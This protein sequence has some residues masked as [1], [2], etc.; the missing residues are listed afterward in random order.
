[1]GFCTCY[2]ACQS[3]HSFPMRSCDTYADSS[4]DILEFVDQCDQSWVVDIDA[5]SIVSS[6][7]AIL[8]L[9]CSHA[10]GFVCAIAGCFR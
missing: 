3:D 4:E 5:A 9:K 7:C 6:V 10:L 2:R 8:L 1:M